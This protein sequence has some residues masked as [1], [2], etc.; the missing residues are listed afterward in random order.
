VR[1]KPRGA[2][3]ERAHNQ[4]G[5]GQQRQSHP[6]RLRKGDTGDFSEEI[7]TAWPSR[8]T[9]QSRWVRTRGSCISTTRGPPDRAG[10]TSTSRGL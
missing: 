2:R 6:N 9:N 4:D 3:G 8:V 1:M 7:R 5:P 10:S